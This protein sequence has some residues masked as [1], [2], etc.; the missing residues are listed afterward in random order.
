MLSIIQ[1]VTPPW[2]AL[3]DREPA[4]WSYAIGESQAGTERQRGKGRVE[5]RT[6]V[7]EGGQI[8]LEKKA[9]RSRYKRKYDKTT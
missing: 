9:E 2:A 3:P 1:L 8:Q 4:H 7:R 6:M 5:K